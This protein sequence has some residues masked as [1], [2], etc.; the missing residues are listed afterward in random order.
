M[1]LHDAEATHAGNLDI[2]VLHLVDFGA[3]IQG[4]L[5]YVLQGREER[6]QRRR[7]KQKRERKKISKSRQHFLL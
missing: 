1:V 5:A 4:L 7:R 6:K 2:E 3:F